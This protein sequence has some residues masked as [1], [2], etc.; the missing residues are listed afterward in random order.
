[1]IRNR[2]PCGGTAAVKA[3]LT[4]RPSERPWDGVANT[5]NTSHSVGLPSH[6]DGS[7]PKSSVMFCAPVLSSATS[8][9][10]ASMGSCTA[11]RKPPFPQVTLRCHGLNFAS[12]VHGSPQRLKSTT[13]VDASRNGFAHTSCNAVD[14]HHMS[15]KYS[16]PRRAQK[17]ARTTVDRHPS[18][19]YVICIMRSQNKR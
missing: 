19:D 13:A 10:G 14:V 18:L 6:S 15:V 1:M 8:V 9:H 17:G 7:T 5:S 2:L 11:H 3:R 16:A 4:N 12:D